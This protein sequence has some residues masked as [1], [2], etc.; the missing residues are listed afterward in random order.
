MKSVITGKALGSDSNIT[1]VLSAEDKVFYL[2]KADAL[3][4]LV[5]A[6]DDKSPELTLLTISGLNGRAAISESKGD[7]DSAQSFYETVISRAGKQ[8]PALASQAQTRIDSLESLTEEV[9]LP[10]D[11]EVTARNNQSEQ[12]ES[13]P[14]NPSIDELTDLTETG[15]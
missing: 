8:Y 3:Y 6:E 1:T 2:E 5:I 10:T 9:I 15:Q 14:I 11:A 12:R 7:I 13:A 4:A